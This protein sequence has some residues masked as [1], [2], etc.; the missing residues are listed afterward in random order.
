VTDPTA[1]TDSFP[2]VGRRMPLLEHLVEL[3][4]RV[5]RAAAGLVA[6]MVVSTFVV[7]YIFAALTAPLRLSMPHAGGDHPDVDAWYRAVIGPLA[8]IASET[9]VKGTL[10]ITSTP[11]DGMYTWFRLAIVGGVLLASPLVAWQIWQFIAP[12][13]YKNERRAVYPLVI[14][15]TALFLSGAAFAYFFILPVAF[16]IFF[17]I[18]QVDAVLSVSGYLTLVTRMMM[19]FGAC[20]QL[21]VVTWFLARLG[22]IDHKDMMGA[23]RYAVVIIFLVAA[24]VTP[25]DVLTQTLLAIPLIVLYGVGIVVAY[26]TSTKVRADGV[27][28]AP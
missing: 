5:M 20:F 26:F 25:P 27:S 1:P 24:I 19:V 13:L 3:R 4:V 6:G 18:I 9:Q 10:A 23:F 16:P 17:G 15:S 12:A 28:A 14:G 2:E 8:D 7:D 21:P 22:F 11:L